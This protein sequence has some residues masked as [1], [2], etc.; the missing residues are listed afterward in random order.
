[1][2]GIYSNVLRRYEMELANPSIEKASKLA[3]S[4]EISFDYL[5]GITDLEMDKSIRNK[6]L[7]IQKLPEDEA[8]HF[9]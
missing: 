7:T 3:E 6:I 4:L 9:S 8:Y 2:V 5:V 1:M